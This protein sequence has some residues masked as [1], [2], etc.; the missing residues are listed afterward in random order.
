MQKLSTSIKQ[1]VTENK[2]QNKKLRIFL[3]LF[4]MFLFFFL[5]LLLFN[6]FEY[7][8]LVKI[9]SFSSCFSVHYFSRLNLVFV[10]VVFFSSLVNFM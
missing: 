5:I 3:F 2:T 9:F 6:E 4:S 1:K 8:F 7:F 10:V